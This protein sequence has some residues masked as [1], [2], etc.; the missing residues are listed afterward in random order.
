MMQPLH[1]LSWGLSACTQP[2]QPI[3]AAAAA[4]LV[5]GRECWPQLTEPACACCRRPSTRKSAS[6]ATGCMRQW[7]AATSR[8]GAVVGHCDRS[9]SLRQQ[10]Q[11]SL[12]HKRPVLLQCVLHHLQCRQGQAASMLCVCSTPARI[13][14]GPA[15]SGSSAH[16]ALPLPTT[17]QHMRADRPN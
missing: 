3:T 7:L 14:R 5:L 1:R 9:A 4:D 16:C 12:L 10:L 2:A 17:P 8:W 11:C 15:Q 13:T 6:R